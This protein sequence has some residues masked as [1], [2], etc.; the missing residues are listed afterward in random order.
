MFSWTG[1]RVLVTGGTGFIGHHMVDALVQAGADVRVLGRHEIKQ[2]GV[3][4]I[5]GDLATFGDA[6][7]LTDI[8]SVFHLASVRQNVAVHRERAEEI[9]TGNL[10]LTLG[11]LKLLKQVKAKP[12]LVFFSSATV[13]TSF[14]SVDVPMDGYALGKLFSESIFRTAALELGFPLLTL[15][16]MNVYGPGDHFTLEGNVIPALMVKAKASTHQ[17]E[18]WGSGNQKRPFLFAPDLVRAALLLHENGI[19]GTEY[20][21]PPQTIL[22]KDLATKIRDLVHPALEIT[23]DTSKPEGPHELALPGVHS[24]LQSFPWTSLN[25]GLHATYAAFLKDKNIVKG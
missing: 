10:A 21:S 8:D 22:I 14:P 7:I 4:W 24:L 5:E 9:L 12:S 3:T 6:S 15:R 17:L 19:T 2:P 1:R 20:V 11:L 16:P 18:V 13:P 23:F 25:D